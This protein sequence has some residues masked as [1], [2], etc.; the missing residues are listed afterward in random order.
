M[1]RL[2]PVITRRHL[3]RCGLLLLAFGSL[4]GWV[5]AVETFTAWYSGGEL[6]RTTL[7]QAPEPSSYGWLL[8]AV[9]VL[10]VLAPQLL[11]WRRMRRSAAVLAVISAIVLAALWV[12]RFTLV[13]ASLNRGFV[14]SSWARYLP[15]WV[16]WSILLGS[17]GVF[18]LLLLLLVRLVPVVA[19]DEIRRLRREPDEGRSTVEA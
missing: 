1:L 8:W 6:G 2:Q 17:F 9:A 12:E 3:D 7:V 14:P 10:A 15:T 5:L 11:W 4:F 19:V 18:G 16:D 13:I